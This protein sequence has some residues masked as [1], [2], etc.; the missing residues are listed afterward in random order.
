MFFQVRPSVEYISTIGPP[1]PKLARSVPFS[2]ATSLPKPE[3]CQHSHGVWTKQLPSK[4]LRVHEV[5]SQ[6]TAVLSP[7][8]MSWPSLSKLRSKIHVLPSSHE[9]V[10]R[11]IM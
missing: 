10:V 5:V 3:E 6:R 4:F 7:Q 1:Q 11:P 8:T 2:I 9:R